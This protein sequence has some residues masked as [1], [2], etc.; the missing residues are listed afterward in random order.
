MTRRKPLAIRQPNG[1]PRRQPEGPSA[2]EVV[3]LRDAALAGMRDPVWATSI[4]RLYLAGKLTSSQ[5]AAG[6]RWADLAAE[7]S[8]ACLAPRQPRSAKLERG[9]ASPVDPDSPQG[10]KEARQHVQTVHAWATA[11][12]ALN[13]TGAAPRTAVR[14]VCEQNLSPVGELQLVA[15]RSGLSALA[16]LWGERK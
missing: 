7:Y 3:R 14:D 8:A 1:Q 4:G 13:R 12:E 5:F 2:T 11:S 9:D 16:M 15:L 6:K 10:Q